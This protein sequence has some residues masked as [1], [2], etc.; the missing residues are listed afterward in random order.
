MVGKWN[1]TGGAFKKKLHYYA[2][3]YKMDVR[4]FFARNI[5]AKTKD[6]KLV[7]DLL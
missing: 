7:Q 1:M 3:K 6:I 2:A 4:A 5:Y